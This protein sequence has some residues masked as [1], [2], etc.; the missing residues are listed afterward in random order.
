[1]H[2]LDFFGL[3]N[4]VWFVLVG[5]VLGLSAGVILVVFLGKRGLF[6]RKNRFYNLLVKGYYLYLPL[7]FT[8][9]S[10]FLSL[11]LG[12]HFETKGLF[13]KHQVA[14]TEVSVGAVHRAFAGIHEA[15]AGADIRYEFIPNVAEVVATH[16]DEAAFQVLGEDLIFL[17]I[18]SPIRYSMKLSLKSALEG[19]L[20][21]LSPKRK[22]ISADEFYDSFQSRVLQSFMVG[23]Y[24]SFF[25]S[26]VASQFSPIYIRI[27]WN[28][29]LFLFPVFFELSLFL[30]FIRKM[31]KKSRTKVKLETEVQENP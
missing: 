18:V 25:W 28:T 20:K 23:Y 27:F 21:L 2:Y 14:L 12:L 11:V 19:D 9:S 29:F 10:L 15:T 1:M 17:E 26:E 8:I 31:E 16:V 7:V 5:C 30:L 3:K 24:P 22:V 13:N 4:F 6:K